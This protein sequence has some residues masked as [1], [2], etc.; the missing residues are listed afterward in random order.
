MLELIENRAT[1]VE[2]KIGTQDIV[3]LTLSTCM[4]CKKCKRYL[5][6]HNL[7]YRYIDLDKIEPSEKSEILSYLRNNYSERISYPFMLYDNDQHI[8]G[9]DPKKYEQML[10]MEG[11]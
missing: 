10:K 11:V 9:Y 1:Q 8:I 6:E 5:Q 3:I 7:K 4:W 2:G